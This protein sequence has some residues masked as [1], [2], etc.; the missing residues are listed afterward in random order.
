MCLSQK[1]QISA[2]MAP[3][4]TNDFHV[5]IDRFYREHIPL[6]GGDV[7]YIPFRKDKQYGF[8]DKRT[9]AQIIAPKYAQVFAVYPEGAIVGES[10]THYGLLSYSDTFI[11]PPYFSNLYKEGNLYHGLL[12][13]H[14]TSLDERYAA[15]TANLYY[16]GQGQ[17]LFYAL[18]HRQRSFSGTDTMAWF[19]YADTFSVYG[20]SGAL[21]KKIPFNKTKLF[22]GTFNNCLVYREAMP[23]S[24]GYAW[25]SVAGKLRHKLTMGPGV[26]ESV[27]Y[28]NDTT[29][30]LIDD[31]GIRFV[32]HKGRYY[33]Y[34]VSNGMVFA[35]QGTM[36]NNW[37]MD[38]ALL[39]VEDGDTRLYGFLSAA[40]K[41]VVP[42]KY[43]YVG[44]FCEWRSG[45]AGPAN[46]Q[47]RLY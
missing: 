5:M 9:R 43:R 41:M 7:R 42:C 33:N 39:P 15:Y 1:R 35:N 20:I 29:Y 8:V 10:D 2:E 38:A 17:F 13:A 46:Q 14:D 21:L 40:G 32:N 37:F 30:A 18:A 44:D 34:G 3:F 19:R 24:S 22:I 31:E 28:L 47:D 11:I 27:Y 6:N 26:A 23:E 4:Y 45:C 16:N 12:T 36:F 25:Y